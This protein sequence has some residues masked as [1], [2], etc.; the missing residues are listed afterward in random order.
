MYLDRRGTTFYDY[1]S[2]VC[3]NFF[4]FMR[5]FNFEPDE[6][7]S[8]VAKEINDGATHVA[9]KAGQGCGKTTIEVLAGLW[10]A[11]R[12]FGALCVVTAPTMRQAKEVWLAEARARINAAPPDVKRF[13]ECR[14][15]EIEIMGVPDWGI[16]LASASRP[17]NMQGWHNQFLTFIIDEAS[18]VAR[19]IIETIMGTMTNRDK[20]VLMGG[21]P[22]TRDSAF[23]DCFNRDRRNW[24][25]HT[26][27]CRK[28]EF[29]DK[30]NIERLVE[31]YG[32]NSDVVR[33]RVEGEFPLQ[34]PNCV[35]NSDDLEACALTDMVAASMLRFSDLLKPVNG[36]VFFDLMKQFGVDF[37]RFG[38]D[39]SQIYR[40]S[41]MAIVEQRAF[42]KTDP[43]LVVAAAFEMQ[44]C[45]S[46]RNEE[47]WYVPDAEGMGQGLMHHFHNAGKQIHEFRAGGVPLQAN[48]YHDRI[49]EAMFHLA[50]LAKTRRIHIPDDPELIAQLSNRQ[51]YMTLK[52]KIKLE[53]KD[54]YK[55]RVQTGSP[56]KADAAALSF[57]NKM[58]SNAQLGTAAQRRHA[59]PQFQGI[60]NRSN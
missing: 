39:L 27:S 26:L 9:M 24:S 28:S 11:F 8:E 51:Y 36:Q 32:I 42:A 56:D 19:N 21:N 10:R 20:L 3:D 18:G 45:A 37:A 31:L 44:R 38:D 52:G 54:E 6:Q 23:F 55:K 58:L 35:M 34:D 16:K 17:E 59:T 1:F 29:V 53:S 5:S 46:W 14:A 47:C 22:N 4:A 43:S 50:E 57:Y 15:T 48:I 60:T 7:Q 13:F 41:G 40:R 12:R 33:V 2:A 25:T 49:T 30:K